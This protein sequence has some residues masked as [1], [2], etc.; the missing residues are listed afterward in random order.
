MIVLTAAVVWLV[1]RIGARW[2][3]Q[4]AGIIPMR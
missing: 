4:L 1:L 2:R 3:R